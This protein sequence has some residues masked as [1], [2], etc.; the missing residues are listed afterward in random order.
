MGR[1]PLDASVPTRHP[2]KSM[3]RANHALARA[4][5]E[6]AERLDRGVRYRWAHMGSCNCG[7][8]AQTLT[9]LTPEEIHERALERAGDW[10]EQA[11]EFC[12]TS[13]LPI[14][15][16]IQTMLDSGLTRQDIGDLEKLS[17]QAILQTLPPSDRILD[18]RC[19]AHVVR[20]LRAWA[21]LLERQL[22]SDHG[23]AQDL[24]RAGRVRGRAERTRSTPRTPQSV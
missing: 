4:L 3:T 15:D 18:R 5:T 23:L 10:S 21:R 11:V 16:V 2:S 22:S 19:R 8:L 13:R 1:T 6:T 12:P 24:A 7:H 17:G 9:A 20:Y 14:D